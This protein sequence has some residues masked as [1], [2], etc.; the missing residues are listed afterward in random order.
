MLLRAVRRSRRLT[1][2]NLADRIDRSITTIS[3]IEC[4]ETLLNIHTLANLAR[5]LDVPTGTFFDESAPDANREALMAR[6]TDAAQ[7][8]DKRTLALAIAHIEALAGLKR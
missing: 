5:A 4:G 3:K 2:D 1:Q 7:E 8:L 6:L